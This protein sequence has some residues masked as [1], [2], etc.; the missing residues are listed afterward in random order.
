[1]TTLAEL[2]LQA[3]Q[4]ADMVKSK[5]VSDS[6]LTSYI[7]SEIAELYDLLCEC[8]G[9]DYFLE[10]YEFTTT[11]DGGYVLPTDFYELKRLD[12]KID[13][14][15]WVTVPRFNLNQETALRSSS[16]VALGGYLNTR[17]RLMGNSIKLAPLPAPGSTIRVLYVPLP[18]ILQTDSDT[19]DDFNYYSEMIILGTA[20]KMLL[21]EESDDT[22][23][24]LLQL[25]EQQKQR[26]MA[27]A[28]NRDA[29]NSEQITDIYATNYEY[30]KGTR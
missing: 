22:A 15:D 25:K 11:T 24:V 20:A 7:N 17:Y 3:R 26:I 1:M 27:K 2:K 8:Y 10:E 12:L 30:F 5:F 18:L 29:A 16:F 23:G 14:Q 6:E 28:Q 19:L 13:G 9:E 4:R 21:K